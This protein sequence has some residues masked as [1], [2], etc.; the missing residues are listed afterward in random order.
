MAT[1]VK[2]GWSK[3]ST[4]LFATEYPPNQSAFSYALAQAIESEAHLVIFH[5][6]P[7]DGSQAMHTKEM[8][9]PEYARARLIRSRFEPLAERAKALG[10]QC[11]VVV[12]AGDASD[13][14]L[15]Y[16]H[17]KRV[18]RLFL[19][20]HTPGPVGRFLIGSVAERV[21]RS[22]EAPVGIV[23]PFVNEDNC[24]N[25]AT[26]I[27]L[28]SLGA[29]GHR[30]AVVAFAAELAA[31]HKAQLVLQHV[32][33]PQ[34]TCELTKGRTLDEMAM[35]LGRLIPGDVREKLEFETNVVVGDPTEELLYQGRVRHASLIV[36]GAH[37]ASH[38]AAIT[39]AS[40]VYKVLAYARCPVLTL[41]PVLLRACGGPRSE[42]ASYYDADHFVAGVF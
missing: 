39:P 1:V 5:V 37:D 2:A 12:R 36:L 42:R 24:R 23:G 8:Q 17:E 38:F 15:H 13:E 34:D 32:I 29:H 10:V 19:G 25:C 16:M 20:A 11:R 9:Q 3:P 22:A 35:D 4:I 30:H 28:C 33:P 31:K 40:S 18:D 14:I 7:G 26:R 6:Y 27:I 21:M 41:S